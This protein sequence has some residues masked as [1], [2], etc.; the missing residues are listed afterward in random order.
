MEN[1]EKQ[2]QYIQIHLHY[3]PINKGIQISRFCLSQRVDP[4]PL[5]E[6]REVRKSLIYQYLRLGSSRKGS[7]IS[8]SSYFFLST[9]IY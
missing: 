2:I 7:A 5:H 4:E 3:H 8:S 1:P 9:L 6:A